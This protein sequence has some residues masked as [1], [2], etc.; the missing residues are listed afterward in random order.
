V[1]GPDTKPARPIHVVVQVSWDGAP[2][3]P[4]PG[5]CLAW[6]REYAKVEIRDDATAL[7]FALWFPP[8]DV[9]MRMAPR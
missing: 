5:L 6:T 3:V 9:D 7:V 1:T 2:K 4:I 8:Q